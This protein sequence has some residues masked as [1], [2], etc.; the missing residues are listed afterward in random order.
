MSQ[1]KGQPSKST[2]ARMAG[3]IAAGMVCRE[4]VWTNGAETDVI[5]SVSVKIAKEI[6]RLV[7]TTNEI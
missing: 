5:A 7:D 3:N 2:L 6:I 4:D 1:D